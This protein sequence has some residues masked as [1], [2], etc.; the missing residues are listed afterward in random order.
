[1]I[2]F[3]VIILVVSNGELL[4]AVPS[5]SLLDRGWKYLKYKLNN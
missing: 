5:E 2:A 3:L 1:M 4:S